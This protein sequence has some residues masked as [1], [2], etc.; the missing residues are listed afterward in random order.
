MCIIGMEQRAMMPLIIFDALVNL[1]LTILFVLPL[2]RLY[3]YKQSTNNALRTITIRSFIGSLATLTS[4]VVNLTILMV[5]KG[6]AAWI[7]LMCCNADTLFSVL[8]LHWVTS[9]DSQGGTT[10]ASKS[11]GVAGSSA[12]K[13]ATHA[14]TLESS[15]ANPFNARFGTFDDEITDGGITTYISANDGGKG[16][17]VH[18]EVKEADDCEDVEKKT[19]RSRKGS[20]KSTVPQSYPLNRIQ[21]GRIVETVSEPRTGPLGLVNLE[22]MK[23]TVEMSRG[24]SQG[25]M[26][27]LVRKESRV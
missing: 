27:D 23:E 15:N 3:S 16:R 9:K 24:D 22:G 7:C 5:L 2:R 4:S 21:V 1:Y 18:V 17:D 25:S 6:E 20:N 14:S 10:N 26:E 12:R 8:V 13:G 11:G 19:S